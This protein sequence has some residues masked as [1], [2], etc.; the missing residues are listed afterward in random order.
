MAVLLFGSSTLSAQQYHLKNFS[1]SDGLAGISVTCLLQDSRGYIWIGTQDGGISRFDGK[2]FMNYHKHDGIGDNAINCLFE[3]NKGNIWIGTQNNGITKFNGYEFIQYNRSALKN[4]ENIFSDSSGAI[5]IYSFPDLYTLQGDSIV[6]AGNRSNAN[7]LQNFFRAG[8][9]KAVQA[10]TDRNGNK[11][12]ATHSGVYIIDKEFAEADDAIDHRTQFIINSENREEPATSI[13]QDRE[14]NI[15]IGTAFNGVYMFYDG[16]FSNFNNIPALRY[17]FITAVKESDGA[18]FV[19]TT[20]GLKKYTFDPAQNQLQEDKISI[21]GFTSVTRINYIYQLPSGGLIIADEN[22]NCIRYEKGFSHFRIQEI[23]DNAQITAIT[24]DAKGRLWFGTD[25]DGIYIADKTGVLHYSAADSLTSNNITNLFTDSKNNIWIA[26]ADKGIM[27]FDGNAFTA[28]SYFGNGLINDFIQPIAEGPDGNLWFGSPDGGVCNFVNG[29]FIFY[30][31]NDALTSNNVNALQ[32]DYNGNLW[33]G[34]NEGVDELIFNADSTTT[35][36]HFDAYDGFSGI[37]N[38]KN[39]IYCDASN[40]IWFG[41]VNGLFRY[42]PKEDIVS[43]T[44]PLIE[45]RNIRLFYE[46]ADWAPWCD[47]L[48]GWYNLPVNLHLPYDQNH[49][50]FDFSAIF[51]SVHEKIKYQVLLEGFDEKDDWQD[52]GTSTSMTYSNLKPGTYTFYV[53]AQNADGIWSAPVSYSFLIKKPFWQQVAFQIACGILILSGIFLYNFLRNKQL[54][55]RAHQLEETVRLRTAELEQQ[56]IMAEEAALRAERSEKAKEEFLA[57][58]SHEI[59]TPMNAIMGMTRLLLEKDPTSAQLKYLNAIRQSSDNLLVIINDILDLSKI[60]AGKM[61][62]ENIPFILRNLLNNLAEIM[63]FKSDE[64]NIAFEIKIDD[65]IPE[66]VIGDQVRLNQIL[67]NLTGNAIKFTDAGHVFIH[68]KL[69]ERKNNIATIS[70]AVEDTGV[71]IPQDKIDTIFESFSQ[72]DK[73]TTRKFGGT[74]LGLSIS[75][76]LTDLFHGNMYVTSEP[77]KGSVFTVEIPFEIGELKPDTDTFDRLKSSSESISKQ[78]KILLVEDNMF[79]QMVAIDSIE[80]LFDGK[81][82][83]EVAD[84]GQIAVDK[85][86]AGNYDMVLMDVQMPVMDGYTAAKTIRKLS[87]KNKSSIPIVAMTASVI[88]SEV[89]KCYES[90]M[91]DFIAKPFETE[92]LRQ[93]ILKYAVSE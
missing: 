63:K 78:L 47:S 45:L 46:N 54:R 37:K 89:D 18:L 75:K 36:K 70:F 19:G 11:W 1:I 85:I 6:V 35:T 7:K 14:G 49:L 82:I 76:K 12:L 20:N 48:G 42:N 33:I 29:S 66:C 31:E 50:T 59:R 10:L 2:N 65:A 43:V 77:G 88:K 40:R 64:K 25:N 84:N 28:Y 73:A 72:A 87:D 52:I 57:N 58:M 83:V 30:T 93:K 34:L 21:P 90:G 53:K 44:Q 3:D 26:T 38:Y 68:C 60:Q 27:Q 67:I 13:M 15:W 9:Q 22:N 81:A 86:T 61:E 74:G 56:K 41:T 69:V 8:G 16:A 71:G 39:A 23:Q 4:A 80:A 5:M 92:N 51:F 55:K 32:F 24:A 79:N 62:L 91:D 17:G